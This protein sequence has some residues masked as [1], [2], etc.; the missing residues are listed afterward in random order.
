M[1]CCSQRLWCHYFLFIALVIISGPSATSPEAHDFKQCCDPWQS[2]HP[3]KE[4]LLVSLSLSAKFGAGQMKSLTS[5]GFVTVLNKT[6]HYQTHL[7]IMS[8]LSLTNVMLRVAKTWDTRKRWTAKV[9]SSPS[10][11]SSLEWL[12]GY[13]GWH[14]SKIIESLNY[15]SFIVMKAISF[16]PVGREQTEFFGMLWKM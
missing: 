14:V 15:F 2:L 12:P 5:L 16:L 1:K 11:S 9:S 4:P 7:L 10:P 6:R 3:L 8:T 13:M